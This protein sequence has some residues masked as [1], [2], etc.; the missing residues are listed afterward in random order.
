MPFS[1]NPGQ[2]QTSSAQA[3]PVATNNNGVPALNVPV[4][5]QISL[6]PVVEAVSPFAYKNRG[7]SKFS[8][9]FQS[10]I[11]LLFAVVSI[12]ALGLFSYQVMLKSQI[13]GR[14]EKLAQIQNGFKK[15]KIEEIQK[16][17]SR[18]ALINKI[19]KERVSVLAALTLVEETVN[20]EVQYTK[21]SLSKDKNSNGYDLAF[22]GQTNSYSSLYQQLEVIKSKEFSPYLQ[23]ITIAGIS[24]LDKKGLVNFKVYAKAGI[25]G[26]EYDGFTVIHKASQVSTTTENASSTSLLPGNFE[27]ASSSVQQLP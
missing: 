19:V 13:S 24:P 27:V 1:F 5:P 15:P 17:S 21:F 23:K 7:K 26:V 11:F 2:E 25:P 18:L 3:A 8:V 20:P 4:A 16:L 14:E 9:Y 10:A 22:E 6:T 12:A